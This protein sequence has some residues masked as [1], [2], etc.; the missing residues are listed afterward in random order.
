VADDDRCRGSV[1]NLEDV[2]VAP[3]ASVV[4]VLSR[5]EPG[6]PGAVL[7][8]E[9]GRLAGIVTRSDVIRFIMDMTR[10]SALP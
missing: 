7:V 1:E 8:V 10:A 6:G 2:V 4:S 3:T 9:D 5:L